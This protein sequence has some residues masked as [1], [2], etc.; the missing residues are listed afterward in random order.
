MKEQL[1]KKLHLSEDNVHVGTPDVGGGFG[2]KAM[3]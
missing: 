1:A 2:M 3:P